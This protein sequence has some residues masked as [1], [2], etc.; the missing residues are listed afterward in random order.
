MERVRLRSECMLRLS[1]EVLGFFRGCIHAYC[2]SLAHKNNVY[3]GYGE[4]SKKVD[5]QYTC[6]Q[7]IVKNEDENESTMHHPVK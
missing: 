6:T 5:S 1:S 7:L 2:I 4:H 3:W